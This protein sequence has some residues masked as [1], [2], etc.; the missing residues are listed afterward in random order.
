MGAGTCRDTEVWSRHVSSD[1]DVAIDRGVAMARVI[2]PR[3]GHPVL[4]RAVKPRCSHVL[5]RVV[6]PRYGHDNRGVVTCHETE[7][8]S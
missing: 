7:V 3:C 8:G 1:R 4:A 5:A 2:R 6:R